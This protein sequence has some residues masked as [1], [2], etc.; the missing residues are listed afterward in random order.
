MRLATFLSFIFLHK[1]RGKLHSY[2]NKKFAND[3]IG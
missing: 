2:I 3:R 1:K